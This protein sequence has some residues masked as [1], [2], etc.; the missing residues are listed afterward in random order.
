MRWIAVVTFVFFAL[1]ILWRL[2]WLPQYLSIS[3]RGRLK[4]ALAPDWRERF[5]IEV[6]PL[7]FL[8]FGLVLAIIMFFTAP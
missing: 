2:S 8:T 6:I 7:G 4:V 5:I 1:M 3:Y